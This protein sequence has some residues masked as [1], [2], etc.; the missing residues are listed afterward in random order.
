MSYLVLFFST[1]NSRII[2]INSNIIQIYIYRFN[3][4]GYVIHT[5]TDKMCNYYFYDSVLYSSKYGLISRCST[6]H[7]FF[8]VVKKD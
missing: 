3:G 5:H 1:Y 6:S 4:Y 2:Q 8:L 7:S